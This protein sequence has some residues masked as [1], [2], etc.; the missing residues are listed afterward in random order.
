MTDLFTSIMQDKLACEQNFAGAIMIYQDTRSVDWMLPE[1]FNNEIVSKFWKLIKSGKTWSEAGIELNILP[2]LVSWS[3]REEVFAKI[4]P[5]YWARRIKEENY[6]LICAQS[7]TKLAKAIDNHDYDGIRKT[8][9][10]ELIENQPSSKE[11][12][13]DAADV[14]LDFIAGLENETQI[15][16]TYISKL[17]RAITGLWLGHEIVICARSSVGKTALAWQIARNVAEAGHKVLFISL[18][19]SQ[20]ALWA[21]AVCGE[22][23]IQYRDVLAK[24]Y[25]EEGKEQIIAKTNELIEKYGTNL[26]IKDKP[27][28]TTSDIWKLVVDNKPDVVIVDHLRFVG[29]NLTGEKEVKRLGRITQT[30][31]E[32]GKI[33][34]PAMIVL[35]QLN[36]GFDTRT[37]KRPELQDLRD[38][39]EIEEN[40]DF[41]IGI[42]RE[43]EYL[44]KPLEKSPADLFV[45]KFREGPSNIVIHLEFDGLAQWFNCPE[46]QSIKLNDY[47][48]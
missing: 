39:G 30:L 44:D 21:R 31:R 25:T 10:E 37:D 11:T 4:R 27:Q 7:L 38:S 41:V 34:G 20:R 8:A 17:D 48:V 22:L 43:R 32:I 16:P 42:H 14:G 15:I 9:I 33:H 6:R 1:D 3:N 46:F 12:V 45:M 18:E 23:R 35:A 2:D 26:L 47:T 29:D 24:A 19:M 13:P 40:A 36:R 5:E 28:Q